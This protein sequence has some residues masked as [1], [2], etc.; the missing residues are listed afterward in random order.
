MSNRQP[1]P[2]TGELSEEELNKVSGGDTKTPTPKSPTPKSPAPAS[3]QIF[4]IDDY[5]F[6]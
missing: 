3:G 5:S 4:E 2:I 1:E 6:D